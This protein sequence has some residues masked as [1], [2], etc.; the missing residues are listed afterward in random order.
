M[1]NS[2]MQAA[3]GVGVA[4]AAVQARRSAPAMQRL[5]CSQNVVPVGAT[6]F[7]RS[8]GRRALHVTA[9]A[10]PSKKESLESSQ[11]PTPKSATEAVEIGTQLFKD[12]K[13][14]QAAQMFSTALGAPLDIVSRQL[15]GCRAVRLM[16]LSCHGCSECSSIGCC[17]VPVGWSLLHVSRPREPTSLCWR[18]MSIDAQLDA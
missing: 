5:P 9:A 1:L 15:P 10:G 2:A 4:R 14:A 16:L 8:R 17:R 18:R 3:A 11:L 6:T 12:G 13:A 7:Q